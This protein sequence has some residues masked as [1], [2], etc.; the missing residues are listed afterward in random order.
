MEW[1]D[2]D[3]R[4]R[5]ER[6]INTEGMSQRS[7]ALKIGINPTNLNQVMLGNRPV[8]KKLPSKIVLAF[9]EVRIDWIMY[10]SGTNKISSWRI[11]FQYKNIKN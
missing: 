2:S 11:L 10:G 9:P 8:P 5:I 6:L 7:F 3:I 4:D 1:I